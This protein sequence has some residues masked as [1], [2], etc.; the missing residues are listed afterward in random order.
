MLNPGFFPG[1]MSIVFPL[2]PG[3]AAPP[4]NQFGPGWHPRRQG[5]ADDV[6]DL[7]AGIRTSSRCEVSTEKIYIY[8][9]YI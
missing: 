2:K 5:E 1:S 9:T 7:E 4:G 6:G 3:N 8:N